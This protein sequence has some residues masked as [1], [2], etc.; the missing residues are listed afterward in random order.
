MCLQAIQE[1]AEQISHRKYVALRSVTEYK[2]EGARYF[3]DDN[4][5]QYVKAR[6]GSGIMLLRGRTRAV[7][8]GQ[9]PCCAR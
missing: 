7:F 1:A 6:A 9:G 3:P 2:K 8:C 5:V 4:Y